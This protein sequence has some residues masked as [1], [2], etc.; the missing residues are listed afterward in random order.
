MN[1]DSA[2]RPPGPFH[3]PLRIRHGCD[4]TG[5]DNWVR[6]LRASGKATFRYG[7][8]WAAEPRES[9]VPPARHD[10]FVESYDWTAGPDPDGLPPRWIIFQKYRTKDEALAFCRAWREKEV[11][12]EIQYNKE[13]AIAKRMFEQ[14]Q[15]NS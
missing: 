8:T 10:W 6:F 11:A 3:I 7:K 4:P 14:W 9:F 1:A 2:K 5:G 15:K 13:M 12:D